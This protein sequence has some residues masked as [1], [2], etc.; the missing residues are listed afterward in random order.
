MHAKPAMAFAG[1]VI[2]MATKSLT[3]AAYPGNAG[4]SPSARQLW[5]P[6]RRPPRQCRYFCRA[7]KN[8]GC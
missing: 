2:T 8:I 5:A 4:V 6:A 3:H 1:K 7:G